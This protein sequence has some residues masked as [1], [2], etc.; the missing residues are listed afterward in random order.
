MLPIV[1]FPQIVEQQMSQ[2]ESVFATDEQRKHF[3]EYVTGLIAGDEGTVTS[4]N[5]LFLDRNDQSAL[6][7][8]LTQAKWDECKLNRRRVQ[9][10]LARL[11][12]RQVSEKAGRLVLDDTLAHHTRC[13]IEWLAYLWDHAEQRYVWAHDVVTSY[14]V[15]RSDQFPVDFRLWYRTELK[16]ECH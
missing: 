13:S 15:N 1:S 7:R 6:N 3:R 14:Y 2:F 8:F 11:H 16:Q 4:I 9:M 5:N 10:E 12:R